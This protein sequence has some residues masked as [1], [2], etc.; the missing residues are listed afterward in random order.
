MAFRVDDHP[1]DAEPTTL[2]YGALV[3][4]VLGYAVSVAGQDVP[5]TA[6]EFLL[7]KALA[8]KPYQV[9]D[10]TVLAAA[11]Q[12]EG[13]GRV[14]RPMSER[15]VDLHISRLRRKLLQAG[16]DGIQT[17]RFIGYRFVPMVASRQSGS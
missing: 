10:R 14:P 15:A 9:Q 5:V 13:S 6:T 4:E 12:D 2:R 16:Y 1:G 3:V 8:R 11:V 7:L 17:M